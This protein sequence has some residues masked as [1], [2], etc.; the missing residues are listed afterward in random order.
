MGSAQLA[1]GN[2]F[3]SNAFNMVV[4][5]AMD[6]ADPG[7]VYSNVSAGNAVSALLAIVLMSLGVAAIV[8]RAE[9]RLSLREPNSLVMVLVYLAG[10]GLVYSAGALP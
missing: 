9:R 8:F 3:G 4:F 2:L 5:F 6:L 7:S 1:V 10:L